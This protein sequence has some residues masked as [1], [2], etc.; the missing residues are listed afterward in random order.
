MESALMLCSCLFPWSRLK[1][2]LGRWRR[3]LERE[4][5]WLT[6]GEKWSYD[7][8]TNPYNPQ[9][10]NP[11][12]FCW[13]DP[14]EW[15][16]WSLSLSS[17]EFWNAGESTHVSNRLFI[18]L[19]RWSG[20]YIWHID[21]VLNARYHKDIMRKFLMNTCPSRMMCRT[22]PGWLCNLSHC[23]NA[24]SISPLGMNL[25]NDRACC[26]SNTIELACIPCDLLNKNLLDT[27]DD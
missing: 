19:T 20:I 26:Y 5:A 13:F 24:E 22:S 25:L 3:N 2:L 8:V 18:M 4:G 10:F 21:N 1:C 23:L 16:R 9:L 11:E 12:W 7:Y 17:D 14:T 15:S 27:V 6:K